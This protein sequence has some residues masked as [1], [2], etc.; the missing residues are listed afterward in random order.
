MTLLEKSRR[1]AHLAEWGAEALQAAVGETVLEFGTGQGI[2]IDPSAE[3]L[4]LTDESVDAILLVNS[5]ASWQDPAGWLA[6]VRRVLRPTGRIV[7]VLQP[8]GGHT[9][10][11]LDG[12]AAA[13]HEQL[14]AAGFDVLPP[15]VKSLRPVD[16][17][18]IA[19]R[20]GLRKR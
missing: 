3:R 8:D 20:V 6:E 10:E 11:E 18:L 12:A 1:S 13:E 14:A 19:G 17:F 9:L 5:V 16:A 4:P 15:L 7:S 2:G